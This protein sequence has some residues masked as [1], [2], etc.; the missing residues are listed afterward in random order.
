MDVNFLRGDAAKARK[1]LKWKPRISFDQ[2][3]NEMM[4]EDL[5]VLK[6]F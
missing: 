2:L 5:K 3:V 4:T 6:K 1:E